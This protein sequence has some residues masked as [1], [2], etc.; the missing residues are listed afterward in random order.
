MVALAERVR[1]LRGWRRRG[2]AFAAGAVSVLAMAPF[3]AWPVLWAT[4]PVLV[5]LIDGAVCPTDPSSQR[6]HESTQRE[7]K[8]T[9]SWFQRP[10]LAAAEIGWWFGFGYFVPGL[11]W[12]GEAFLVEAE[13]FAILLPFAVTLLPRASGQV[14][15]AACCCWHWRYQRPNS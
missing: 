11:F 6:I 3:F 9:A 8:G 12:V 10:A 2:A 7:S 13:T 14:A 5:W 1:G 4:L 15:A